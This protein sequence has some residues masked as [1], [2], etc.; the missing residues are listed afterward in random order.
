M[1]IVY[2]VT[3]LSLPRTG[4]GNYI[5]GSLAGLAEAAGGD[6]EIVALAVTG[7]RGLRAIPEALNGVPVT[8]QLRFFP[9]ARAWRTAW[10]RLGRPALE[11]LV[12]RFDV[13]H[14]S[15]WWYPP[16]AAGLRTTMIHDV[17]PLRF[18][19]WVHE[20]TLRLHGAKYREAARS[21]DL[22]FVNSAF[23]AGE[24]EEVL[25]VP[26]ERIRV[27]HPGVDTV[28]RPQGRRVDRGHP[29]VLAL[30]PGEP[31]KNIDVLRAS[32]SDVELFVPS[33]YVTDDQ[34]AALYRGAAVFA[35]PSRYEGFGMPIVE[36]MASGV[37][38][39]ASTHAS[40][41]EACGEVALRADPDRPAE[42]AAA[43]ERALAERDERVRRGLEWAC[44]FTWGR[45]GRILMDAL[46]EA[47]A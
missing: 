31:R 41:D 3:P 12:G 34:L 27:A 6:H 38:V 11:R 8:R 15:D 20:R 40:L 4:I 14:F 2:D 42:W 37:P 21:C 18:P 13:L 45:T 22:V 25:G 46:V 43:I 10:S 5:R 47:A 33:G 17:I 7:P 16:Q 9:L 44:G 1:R 28:F 26:A 24:V 23:T 36:A 39:V 32:V 29:Y 19:H 35:Y 30:D